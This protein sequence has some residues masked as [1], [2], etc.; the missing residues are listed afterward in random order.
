DDA[1]SRLLTVL[2]VPGTVELSL[3]RRENILSDAH[4]E[5]HVIE[6]H[7]HAVRDPL[8]DD[9]RRLTARLARRVEG[10]GPDDPAVLLTLDELDR[11]DD[12]GAVVRADV[13]RDIAQRDREILPAEGTLLDHPAVA[14]HRLLHADDAVPE[15]EVGAVILRLRLSLLD[16]VL[17]G[18]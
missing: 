16:G 4:L 6:V 5:A 9:S 15:H 3:M 18:L 17:R 2:A 13:L 8:T 12:L 11:A 14:G 10:A 1:A 7:A